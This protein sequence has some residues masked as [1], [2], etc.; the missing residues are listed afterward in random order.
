MS[1][2]IPAMGT[3]SVAVRLTVKK[4]GPADVPVFVKIAG[5]S[6]E[7][8]KAE[9]QARGRGPRVVPLPSLLDF[10]PTPCL[11]PMVREVVL[12]NDS[13]IPAQVQLFMKSEQSR[14][15][16]DA[17]ALLL[18]PGEKRP[19]AIT[20]TLDDT[21]PHGDELCVNVLESDATMV[22]LAAR[23]TGTTMVSDVK[24]LAGGIDFGQV[25]TTTT[26]TYSFTL[27]NR[28]RRAQFVAFTNMSQ[29]LKELAFKKDS[30]QAKKEKGKGEG[31]GSLAMGERAAGGKEAAAA[32]P[33]E[34]TPAVFAVEPAF[35]TVKPR[36]SATF[37]VTC[38]YAQ[39]KRMSED[40]ECTSKADGDAKLLTIYNIKA[41]A[42]FVHPLLQ[43]DRTGLAF[44]HAHSPQLDEGSPADATG[45]IV[46]P[47][48]V[49]TQALSMMNVTGLPLDF[50]L[51]TSPPFSLDAYEVV[52]APG[53]SAIVNVAFDPLYRD[54]R[55]SHVAEG[56]IVATYRGHPRRDTVRLAADIQ[57]PNI[58]LERQ[59]IDFGE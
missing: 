1:G 44:V 42:E 33:Q 58:V 21:V 26:G 30:A 28:G 2:N 17:S 6:G 59:R 49:Q 20:A 8:L 37:T 18:A 41:S 22:M 43:F 45:L 4:H 36:G 5:A 53:Q 12:H 35:A 34:L 51:R 50:T 46:L 23:G 52:L 19:V 32:K 47:N 10:G 31:S 39:A 40:L 54:D 56:S 14:F 16:A 13:L 7:P 9:C 55:V 3:A 25:F 27:E 57:F 11:A 15:E 38:V 48:V 29:R 24:N